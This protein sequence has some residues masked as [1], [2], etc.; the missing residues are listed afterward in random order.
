MRIHRTELFKTG[1]IVYIKNKSSKYYSKRAKVIEDQHNRRVI[2]I[3]HIDDRSRS[4]RKIY[5]TT[6]LSRTLPVDIPK[7]EYTKET[8]ALSFSKW[9]SI[10]AKKS[11]LDPK[12]FAK[13]FT[14]VL[15][16]STVLPEE[17]NQNEV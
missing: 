15:Y 17:E 7:P 6:S 14:D 11:E 10:E 9:C 2:V 4:I 16:E 1:D 8:M 5:D 3:V 13:M 12:S